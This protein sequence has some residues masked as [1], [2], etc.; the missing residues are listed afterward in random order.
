M[1]TRF[2]QAQKINKSRRPLLYMV[3]SGNDAAAQ[4]PVLYGSSGL[5]YVFI[6][7]ILMACIGLLL[8]I[9]LRVQNINYQKNIFEFNQ[10]ILLEEERADRLRLEVS[11]LKSPSRIQKVAGE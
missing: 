3:E 11:S 7:I 8:N 1:S 10:M 5:F 9:G 6:I 4:E 2:A